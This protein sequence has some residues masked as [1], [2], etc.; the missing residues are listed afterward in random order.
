MNCPEARERILSSSIDDEVQA[1]L[2]ECEACVELWAAEGRLAR[3]L[4]TVAEPA[5]DPDGFAKVTQ[6]TSEQDADAVWR[7]RSMPTTR[8]V[9]IGFCAAFLGAIVYFLAWRRPDWGVYPMMRMSFVVVA[10]LIA[11]GFGVVLSMP[12]S[13]RPAHPFGVRLTMFA[14]LLAIPFVPA[15]FPAAHHAH[16]ASQVAGSLWLSATKCFG[17]G[18]L[19]AF[20]ALIV[21]RLLQREHKIELWPTLFSAVAAAVG[22]NL[23]LQMHC[24]IVD[25]MHIALGH[26]TLAVI[27]AALAWIVVRAVAR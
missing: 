27:Y 25:P 21:I 24:P 22:A 18:T 3:A 4:G 8:R 10:M 9:A 16:E 17:L 2:G 7:L 26:G 20:P 23:A 19:A 6:I 5:S 12:R 11:T 1:H 15:L 13:Y 14:F